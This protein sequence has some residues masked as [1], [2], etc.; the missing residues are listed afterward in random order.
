MENMY[1]AAT[2]NNWRAAGTQLQQVLVGVAAPYHWPQGR[3]LNS[4]GGREVVDWV[5]DPPYASAVCPQA[6]SRPAWRDSWAALGK[7]IPHD[8]FS[9][10]P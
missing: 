1:T 3:Y 10:N 8:M 4:L 6:S 2:D 9:F 7:Y 5:L